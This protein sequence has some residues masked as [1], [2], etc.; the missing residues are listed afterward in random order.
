MQNNLHELYSLLSF[1][2]PKVFSED[3]IEEF[4]NYYSSVEENTKQ[5]MLLFLLYFLKKIKSKN[6]ISGCQ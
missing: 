1:V 2:E 4:V 6:V 3:D 5:G